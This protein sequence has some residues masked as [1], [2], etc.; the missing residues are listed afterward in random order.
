MCHD[1]IF[2]RILINYGEG[3]S[4]LDMGKSYVKHS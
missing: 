1:Y 2:L 3:K 4:I